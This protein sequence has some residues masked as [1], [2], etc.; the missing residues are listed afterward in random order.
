MGPF[1]KEN[2]AIYQME[3]FYMWMW[4]DHFQLL[5][6]M[7]NHPMQV[8]QK[9]PKEKA[10]MQLVN[11]EMQP[12]DQQQQRQ[13]RHLRLSMFGL[14]SWVREP[15]TLKNAEKSLMVMSTTLRCAHYIGMMCGSVKLHYNTSIGA[16]FTM[17]SGFGLIDYIY[18][19]LCRQNAS[20]FASLATFQS[21]RNDY[22]S[23]NPRVCM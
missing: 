2:P 21:D 9:T 22:R 7:E 15:L 19:I 17:H 16:N 10:A 6:G 14:V 5:W 3:M 20:A 1:H 4:T 8:E 11:L 18:K 13:E 23:P 12:M